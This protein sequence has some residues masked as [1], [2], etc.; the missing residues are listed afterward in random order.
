[1]NYQV[2]QSLIWKE[3]RN[4]SR[5]SHRLFYV[6]TFTVMGFWSK[7]N[8]SKY[9]KVAPLVGDAFVTCELWGCGS[10]Y[11]SL[12]GMQLCTISR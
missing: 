6:G 4:T 2:V 8:L 7:V 12:P 9:W 5:P 10:V 11:M 3:T 1:M